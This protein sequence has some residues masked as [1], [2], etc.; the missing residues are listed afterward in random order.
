MREAWPGNIRQLENTLRRAIVWADGD[1]VSPADIK[2]AVLP[3]NSS[4]VAAK[5]ILDQPIDQ[6]ID[7]QSI[8][9][10]VAR[11]YLVRAIETARGN[12]S[13]A[14]EL[15][16]LGSYQTFTNWMDRY[17]VNEAGTNLAEKP[18]RVQT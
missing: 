13:K 18:Q 15:V 11:H 10:T 8:I 16:G 6:G 14:A 4:G 5:S 17:G 7:I 2:E 9:R 12:K 3:S 1:V